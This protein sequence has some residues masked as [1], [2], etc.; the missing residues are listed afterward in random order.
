MQRFA[1]GKE[2]N[3]AIRV[4]VVNLR[5]LVATLILEEYEAAAAPHLRCTRYA[6]RLGI[7]SELLSH[8]KRGGNAVHLFRIAETCCDEHAT[9]RQPVEKFGATRVE[10]AID[11][12]GERGVRSRNSLQD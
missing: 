10:V 12:L 5:V 11:A 3:A 9:V 2:A 6:H 4:A 1:I 7:E 8:A